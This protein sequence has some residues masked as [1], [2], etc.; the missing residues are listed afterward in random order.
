[1]LFVASVLSPN[2]RKLG[3]LALGQTHSTSASLDLS[4]NEIERTNLMAMHVYRFIE[5][6]LVTYV[7]HI[8]RI[9]K[10]FTRDTN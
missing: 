6:P 7:Q 5:W 4:L 3:L 8:Q 2:L 9:Q 10:V 1:M